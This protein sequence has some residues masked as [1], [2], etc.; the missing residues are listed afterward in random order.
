MT[1]INKIYNTAISLGCTAIKNVP[2]C[3]YTS[4][5]IGGPADLL[6]KPDTLE[7]TAHLLEEC[8][9]LDVPYFILGRGSNLVISDSGFKGAVICTSE[10]NYCAHK[11]DGIVECGAGLKLWSLCKFAC[12]EGLSGLEFAYGI[13][14]SVGGAAYMNA[15]AYD[16]EMKNVLRA[17]S[18]IDAELKVGTLENQ[19]LCLGYRT[20]V[21]K[22]NGY[23]ITGVRVQLKYDDRS[24][25]EEK[26][27]CIMNNR[28]E[29]QPLDF[30]SA[31]S[32]F[33]RPEGNYAGALIEMCNLKGHCVGGAKISE[34]HAGF[35]VNTGQATADDVK[36]L[37]GTVKDTVFKK[38]GIM[39]ETEVEFL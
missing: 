38:T 18:H 14:G 9:L 23:F 4:F 15:G 17:C 29:K 13:P 32:V 20:S 2:L 16:G 7:K 26:M 35:I 30:P 24:T 1:I 8:R 39:L 34:K 19:H 10:L 31:G 27:N 3:D 33:K 5:K 12:E 6:V 11:G 36:K 37:V 25:I 21:Y 22:T 28:K